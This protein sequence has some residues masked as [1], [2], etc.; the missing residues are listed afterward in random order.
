[1]GGQMGVGVGGGWV[2]GWRVDGFRVGD[3]WG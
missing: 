1:M 2:N 3:R